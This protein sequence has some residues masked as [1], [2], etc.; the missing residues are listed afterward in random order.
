ELN[1]TYL[2]YRLLDAVT[3]GRDRDGLRSIVPFRNIGGA[4]LSPTGL[5]LVGGLSLS[6]KVPG[7]RR[8]SCLFTAVLC[9]QYSMKSRQ[10]MPGG[11][12]LHFTLP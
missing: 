4:A 11:T 3:C 9:D 12:E 8:G 7:T 6:Q 5:D 1:G 2:F 10:P